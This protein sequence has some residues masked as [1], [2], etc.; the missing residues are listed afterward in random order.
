LTFGFDVWDKSEAVLNNHVLLA[1]FINYLFASLVDTVPMVESGTCETNCR[2]FRP[3]PSGILATICWTNGQFYELIWCLGW[4]ASRY[5][6]TQ[7]TAA[8]KNFL[9]NGAEKMGFW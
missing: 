1:C 6:E 4:F 5:S 8:K 9:H 2:R 3:N 7:G